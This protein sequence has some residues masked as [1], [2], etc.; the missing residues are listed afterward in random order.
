MN[1][2]D[3]CY[4]FFVYC[5]YFLFAFPYLFM[6]FMDFLFFGTQMTPYLGRNS[7]AK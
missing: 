5:L 1:E 3:Y 6:S 7:T 2:N 4:T